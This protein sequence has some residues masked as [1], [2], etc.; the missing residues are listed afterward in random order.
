METFSEYK[1]RI[2]FEDLDDIL[3]HY[4]VLGMKWGVRRSDRE[5]RRARRTRKKEG[6]PV[7]KTKS[8]DAEKAE[9][10]KKKAKK[11]GVQ[12]LTNQEL[13]DLNNRLNL[14]QN[15]NRLTTSKDGGKIKKGKKF[16]DETI[17]MG[18]SANK[19]VAFVNS[20]VGKMLTAELKK[21]AKGG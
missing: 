4:G 5:L 8:E 6:K 10:A 2:G 17:S 20:P 11:G 12:T 13:K 7:T 18:E 16:V 3:E 9:S 19:A 21:K 15:Y 14:E 1:E